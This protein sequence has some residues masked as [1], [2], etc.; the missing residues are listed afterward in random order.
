MTVD[1]I[2]GTVRGIRRHP[3]GNVLVVGHSNTIPQIMAALTGQPDLAKLMVGYDDL[4]VL[5][6]PRGLPPRVLHLHYG[7]PSAF[8]R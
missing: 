4:F 8:V 6:L 5:T 3:G 2:E 1:A 7:A